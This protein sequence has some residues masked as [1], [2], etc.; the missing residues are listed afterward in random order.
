MLLEM[1]AE[2]A[3]IVEEFVTI[4]VDTEIFFS[5]VLKSLNLNL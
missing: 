3:G 1:L 2:A 4:W 5:L